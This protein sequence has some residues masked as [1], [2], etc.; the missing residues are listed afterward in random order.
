MCVH[1]KLIDVY[2]LDL[3]ISSF[4]LQILLTNGEDGG[5]NGLLRIR[6]ITACVNK[7][8]ELDHKAAVEFGSHG[9]S[10]VAFFDCTGKS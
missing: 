5:R 3:G 6:A 8:I 9:L 4:A 1:G 10:A 7:E 2:L